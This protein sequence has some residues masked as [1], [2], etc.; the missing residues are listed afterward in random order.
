[1]SKGV[2][3][4]RNVPTLECMKNT[5]NPDSSANS[6]CELYPIQAAEIKPINSNMS[7]LALATLYEMSVD[8][9]V[10]DKPTCDDQSMVPCTWSENNEHVNITCYVG[11][12]MLCSQ[13]APAFLAN[14][15]SA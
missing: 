5:V 9:S 11:H 15:Y 8:C 3:R 12:V 6:V 7:D 10:F 14:K 1:M 13:C 4:A 2:Q